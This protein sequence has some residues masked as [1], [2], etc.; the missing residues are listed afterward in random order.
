MKKEKPKLSSI[1]N[2]HCPECDHLA[3]PKNYQEFNFLTMKQ[4]ILMECL[5]RPTAHLFLAVVHIE[6]RVYVNLEGDDEE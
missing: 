4:T 2:I 6:E 1:S 3:V 5:N